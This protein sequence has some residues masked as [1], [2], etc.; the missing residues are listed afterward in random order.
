MR[1]EKT[2]NAINIAI[3]ASGEGT[4]AENIIQY[5]E[6]FLDANVSC[7]ITN[8]EN[9]GV[10]QRIRRY[11]VPI[12]TTKWYKEIDKI[13]TENNVHY[14]IL[15]GYLDKIPPM[16]CKKYK[17]KI[18][19]IHPALLPKH[20]GQGMY[21]DNVHKSVIKSKDKETGITIHFVNEEY[22]NGTIIFQK[23]IKI[24]D[25]EDW[26]SIKSRVRDLEKKFYPT[27]IE[28][29]IKGTYKYLYEKNN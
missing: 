3:L 22:D 19:N 27:V 6:P 12:Y 18:I 24:A 17:H 23:S 8:N 15:A 16:F 28:K 5:F 4:N 21:G 7:V 2:E 11:K 29:F 14:I 9:A 10:I 26:E 13:L 1:L 25:G 20:G